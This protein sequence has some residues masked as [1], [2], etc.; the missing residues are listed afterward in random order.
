VSDR[1]STKLRNLWKRFSN[2]AFRESFASSQ[3]STHV[4]A[5]IQTLRE[6]REWTQTELAE[7]TGMAQSRISLLEDPS[8]ERMT[9]STLKRIASAFDV[10]L[11]VRF[12]PY[13]EL[14]TT[15]VNYSERG[16]LVPSFSEDSLPQVASKVWRVDAVVHHN[17][18]TFEETSGVILGHREIGF[19]VKAGAITH[20][21]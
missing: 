4:A 16:F 11:S 1:I 21:A 8:Y 7:A 18:K 6:E 10:A 5:Q 9:V 13:S 2:R 12:V 14:L 17:D 15:A 19:S 20:A 3:I